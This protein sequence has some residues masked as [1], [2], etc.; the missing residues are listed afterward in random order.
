MTYNGDTEPSMY[1]QSEAEP[2]ERRVWLGFL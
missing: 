1:N 2:I